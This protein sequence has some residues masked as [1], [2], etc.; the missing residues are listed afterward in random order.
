MKSR[1][2]RGVGIT[3]A[4]QMAAEPFLRVV[5][6]DSDTAATFI[7]DWANENSSAAAEFLAQFLAKVRREL[8]T[9]R[10]YLPPRPDAQ[11]TFLESRPS[12]SAI[13]LRSFCRLL[14]ENPELISLVQ[15]QPAY[16]GAIATPFFL[17]EG[18]FFNSLTDS[19]LREAAAREH[20]YWLAQQAIGTERK[21]Q[22]AED[23]QAKKD[24]RRKAVEPRLM[25]ARRRSAEQTAFREK[26]MDRSLQERIR[27]LAWDESHSIKVFP[28][29][30]DKMTLEVL[31]HVDRETLEQ[32]LGRIATRWETYWRRLADRIQIALE[33]QSETPSTKV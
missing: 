32:L 8:I 20:K 25:E 2:A 21:R 18:D 17:D 30:H 19:A 6:L 7:L 23:R 15:K 11:T 31:R 16:K 28:I 13:A 24:A 22:E 9:S 10:S 4:P 33:E 26:F 3:L 14:W 29:E 27:L 12:V 1:F 5:V